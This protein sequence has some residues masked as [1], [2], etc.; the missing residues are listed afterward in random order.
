VSGLFVSQ[1]CFVY[2]V[3]LHMT[4][5]PNYLQTARGLSSVGSGFFTS[6]PFFIASIVNIVVN[7]FGDRALSDN[8][9]KRPAGRGV[10]HAARHAQ[11]FTWL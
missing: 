5:L 7:W 2:S 6:I 1:G 4:W 10:G 11:D 3:Y 8:L 9:K